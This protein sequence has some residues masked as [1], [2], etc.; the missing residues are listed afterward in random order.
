M[1][2]MLWPIFL[3]HF[4]ITESTIGHM[5]VHRSSIYRP[6]I[7]SSCFQYHVMVMHLVPRDRDDLMANHVEDHSH[8]FCMFHVMNLLD[9]Y[10]L[11]CPQLQSTAFV[12]L[13]AVHY[14]DTMV[15]NA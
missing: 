8:D 15:G 1:L 11:L 5:G 12:T 13:Q 4:C 2:D 9:H 7:L 10:H 14:V 3:V 6:Y